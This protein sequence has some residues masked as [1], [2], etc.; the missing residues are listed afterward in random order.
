MKNI[1]H[2][3]LKLKIDPK[4]DLDYVLEKG[5][6]DAFLIEIPR[7]KLNSEL[8]EFFDELG[9]QVRMCQAIYCSGQ[10]K[11]HIHADDK[12]ISD[13]AKI[14]WTWG[15][16]ESELRWWS[17][18]DESKLFICPTPDDLRPVIGDSYVC[19][20]EHNCKLLYS[21]NITKPSLVNAGMLHSVYNPS[22]IGRITLSLLIE[23]DNENI[24]FL[25]AV[26][27]FEKVVE[28]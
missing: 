10:E 24:K 2:R 15:D 8:F 26:K 4:L 7:E 12:K 9:V 27:I 22:P 1:Y 17:I 25:D 20:S 16:P 6:K 21:Q 18:E 5:G 13:F 3:F 14:N 11:I 19:A 28:W 23:K